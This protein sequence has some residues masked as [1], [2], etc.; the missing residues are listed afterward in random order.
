MAT[1]TGIFQNETNTVPAA[2]SSKI[3]PSTAEV[4]SSANST[5]GALQVLPASRLRE[6][7]RSIRLPKSPIELWRFWHVAMAVPREVTIRPG[8]CRPKP[9]KSW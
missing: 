3:D 6:I 5:S 7:A 9:S 4:P 8:R 2:R 1:P